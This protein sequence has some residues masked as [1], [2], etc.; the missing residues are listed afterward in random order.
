MFEGVDIMVVLLCFSVTSTHSLFS[1][2]PTNVST[3]LP[4]METHNT[5]KYTFLR[6]EHM[7]SDWVKWTCFWTQFTHPDVYLLDI[8]GQLTALKYCNWTWYT[9]KQIRCYS[10]CQKTG[11]TTSRRATDIG[12]HMRGQY[13]KDLWLKMGRW[14]TIYEQLSHFHTTH[15]YAI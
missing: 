7:S 12:E 6:E 4:H 15:S 11:W 13:S 8:L 2:L 14:Q 10:K 9:F 1:L 3:L 5:S